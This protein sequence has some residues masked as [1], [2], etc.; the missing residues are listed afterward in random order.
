L[1][2]QCS[3]SV[4]LVDLAGIA[5]GSDAVRGRLADFSSNAFGAAIADAVFERDL[6]T[7]GVVALDHRFS[8]GASGV[9]LGL[10]RALV[11]SS[12]VKSNA[13]NAGSDAPVGGPAASLAG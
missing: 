9:G 10:A 1:A 4:G 12:R 7:I 2:R 8:V 11:A 3:T 13:P 5:C 6:E